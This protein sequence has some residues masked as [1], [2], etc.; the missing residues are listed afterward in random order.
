ML[1]QPIFAIIR[2]EKHEKYSRKETLLN[3]DGRFPQRNRIRQLRAAFTRH[4]SQPAAHEFHILQRY[5]ATF[6]PQPHADECHILPTHSVQRLRRAF[7]A[8]TTWP[9][10]LVACGACVPGPTFKIG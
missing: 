7:D 4:K 5:S 3:L 2:E 10:T 1:D 6:V 8:I 9:G